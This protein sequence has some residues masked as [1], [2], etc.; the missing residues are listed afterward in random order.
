MIYY[1]GLSQC[2]RPLMQVRLYLSSMTCGLPRE[3][4]GDD[5]AWGERDTAVGHL[6]HTTGS[7]SMEVVSDTTS[8]Q[9]APDDAPTQ[10]A[11]SEERIC[12]WNNC[13]FVMHGTKSAIKKVF[14]AHFKEKHAPSCEW[15]GCECE[16]NRDGRCRAKNG[17]HPAHVTDLG[18]HVLRVHMG[19]KDA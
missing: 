7:L 2:S 16:V 8:P 13:G 18:A 10:L 1:R 4:V 14:T 11:E 6:G 15:A 3:G 19:V 17:K 5:G 12:R 9:P